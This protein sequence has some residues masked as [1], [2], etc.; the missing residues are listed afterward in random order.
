MYLGTDIYNLSVDICAVT[1]TW[2]NGDIADDFISITG[3]SIIRKDRTSLSSDKH[4]GG[5]VCVL[6]KIDLDVFLVDDVQ[7]S[8]LEVMWFGH[9]SRRTHFFC[10]VYYPP[11]INR[12]HDYETHIVSVFEQLYNQHTDSYF[13]LFGDFNDFNVNAV[14]HCLPF[15]KMYKGATHKKKQL[16]YIFTTADEF[17]DK[18][19]AIEPTLA[20]DHKAI[21]MKASQPIPIKRIKMS[22]HDHSFSAI[23]KLNF[24]LDNHDFSRIY[25]DDD[26]NSALHSL[27][28]SIFYHYNECCPIRSVTMTSKDPPYLNPRIKYQIQKKN[29]AA[30]KNNLHKVSVL[31]SK[32]QQMIIENI[33]SNRGKK[34]SRNWWKQLKIMS[35][36]VNSYIPSHSADEINDHFCSISTIDDYT[37][38]PMIS[39][40]VRSCDFTLGEVYNALKNI[41]KTSCGPDDLPWFVIKQNAHNFAEP[42]LHIFNRCLQTGTFP[43]SWKLAKVTPLPK[44]SK[45]Q[46]LNDLRPVSVTAVLSR[47]FERLVYDRFISSIYNRVLR[48]NQFGFRKNSSIECALLRLTRICRDFSLQGY[49]Y[50]RIFSLDLSKA[51]D[52]LPRDVIV[53]KLNELRCFPDNIVNLI[54]SFLT[55][56]RQFVYTAGERSTTMETNLGVP[57]GTVWGPILFNLVYDDLQVCSD[58]AALIKFADDATCVI[59]GKHHIDDHSI[60]ILKDIFDWCTERNMSINNTKS[61]EICIK[62]HKNCTYPPPVLGIPRADHFKLLGITISNQLKF[63]KHLEITTSKATKQLF[64]LKKLKDMGYDRRELE[65]LYESLI[66]PVI[67]FGITVWGGSSNCHLEKI[68]RL[69]RKAQNMLQLTSYT[70]IKTYIRN[71][72]TKLFTKIA[73]EPTHLLRDFVPERTSY[74]CERLRQRVGSST[75]KTISIFNNLFPE[76]FLNTYRS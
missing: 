29:R 64:L 7:T 11:G 47:V 63:D 31:S 30:R 27:Y 71:S 18:G 3:Y 53:N 75:E 35:G 58:T 14:T 76:R 37:K 23:Q 50:M 45:I 73:D 48:K 55:N 19:I 8:S 15:V 6:Y 42:L 66:V 57:Q 40:P 17:Y 72:D 44:K 1:E 9:R 61:I 24:S 10:L 26:P 51:F 41:K 36:K 32:I 4:H 2:L 34:S 62:L 28:C 12:Q 49:D 46:F 25:D 68:D 39:G 74:A 38:P 56:R 59:A 20:T 70:P 60:P 16:D 13:T 69:Q 67:T 33:K 65:Q 43:E 52:K 21:F 22:F 5:G 54:S